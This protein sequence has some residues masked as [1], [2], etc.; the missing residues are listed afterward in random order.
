MGEKGKGRKKRKL[1]VMSH[2]GMR[3]T[4]QGDG[5]HCCN[6]YVWCQVRTRLIRGPSV[7][8]TNI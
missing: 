2:G 8:Y 1:P 7:S 4:A 6:N 5:Q 3:G